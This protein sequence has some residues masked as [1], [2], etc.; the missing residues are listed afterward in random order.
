[1]SAVPVPLLEIDNVRKTFPR[2][3]GGEL[4]VLDGVS[5]HMKDGE[6]VG[7]LGRSGSGKSTLLRLIA[8]LSRPSAGNLAYRGDPIEG[9]PLGIAMVFQSFAL[10]PW[11]TVYDNVALGLE[12]QQVPRAD[13]RR[14]SLA[15]IDLIGLDG[16]ESAYPAS[17][18]AACAS[19][20]GSHARSSFIRRSC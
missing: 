3:D 9:P 13:I 15:A 1:M 6:I 5:L 16:Y 17:S 20:S 18:R 14:R 19:G 4:L 12:A 11:L 8:G 10:F 7:L 2:T